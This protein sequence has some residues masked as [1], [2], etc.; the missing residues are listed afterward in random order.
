MKKGTLEEQTY[1][2]LHALARRY[3]EREGKDHTLQPTALVNEAY[4]RLEDQD[5]E[6]TDREH[7]LA[8]AARIMRNVL[9]D[10]ARARD[11]FKRGGGQ[12]RVD[13]EDCPEPDSQG[14]EILLL[15]EA[16]E[17]LLA[18]DEELG[19]VVELRFFGGLGEDEVARA[20]GISRRSVSRRFQAAR[21]WLRDY[22]KK[23]DLC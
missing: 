3:F 23:P 20:L 12:N 7:F 9:V 16:V 17:K 1:R 13:L 15:N 22:L 4:L 14:A 19:R 6:F 21:A 18:Q 10:H 2:E 11:S 8:T 5:A